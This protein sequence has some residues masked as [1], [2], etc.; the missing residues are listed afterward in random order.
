MP[1]TLF[2]ADHVAALAITAAIAWGLS[3][4]VR[5]AP[6]GRI[7]RAVRVALA[8]YL[9][10]A[11]AAVM[12]GGPRGELR[13]LDVLPLHLCD[14]A[15]FI[16]AYTLIARAQ[17]TFELLYFWALT[18][19]L[20]AMLTPDLERG[21]PDLACVSF[22]GIHGGVLTAALLL[23]WGFGMRPRPGAAWKAFLFTNAY[24]ALV[25]IVDLLANTNYMY[26]R[27]KPSTPTL[28][29][30]LGP[31]P[32]YILVSDAIALALFSLLAIPFRRRTSGVSGRS[33]PSGLS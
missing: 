15:I 2:G 10:L 22:F 9:L 29:D 1:F 14:L 25:G 27:A 19:T 20:L 23:T 28:L 12:L 13:L 4:L 5:R 7:A 26:L 18:G 16:A 11:T 32:W 24:A 21:F 17:A 3:R 6:E 31:W 30:W 33:G 8:A